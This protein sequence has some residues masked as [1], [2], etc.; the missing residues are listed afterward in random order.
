MK[1]FKVTITMAVGMSEDVHYVTAVIEGTD[2]DEVFNKIISK[3]WFSDGKEQR[4]YIQVKHIS[5][6]FIREIKDGA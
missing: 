6:I 3:E 4:T 1:K 2:P 5:D